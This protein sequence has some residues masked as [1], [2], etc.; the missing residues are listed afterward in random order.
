MKR[1]AAT[2]ATFRVS[3]CRTSSGHGDDGYRLEIVDEASA[4][5]VLTAECDGKTFARLIT[6]ASVT[7]TG[8]SFGSELVGL[9]LET[10]TYFASVNDSR[11]P[12]EKRDEL[13]A[14]AAEADGPWACEA[15]WTNMHRYTRDGFAINRYRYRAADGSI[16]L[17]P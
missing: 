5:H 4:T 6:S 15:E 16:V 10:S 2:A 11:V 12:V 14:L 9:K 13:L 17:P 7:M 1:T 8:V 3:F